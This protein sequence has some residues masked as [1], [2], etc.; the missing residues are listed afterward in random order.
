[1][2]KKENEQ[3]V[4][5]EAA[6]KDNPEKDAELKKLQDMKAKKI[7]DK[8]VSDDKVLY[9]KEAVTL[10]LSNKGGRKFKPGDKL[11]DKYHIEILMK[12]GIRVIEKFET[13]AQRDER[14]AKEKKDK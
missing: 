8:K 14:L 2:P 13:K 6:K 10:F 5:L 11:D 7:K 9:A 1:M 3:P 4:I 12:S